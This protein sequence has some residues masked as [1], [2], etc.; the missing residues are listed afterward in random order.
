MTPNPFEFPVHH[1]PENVCYGHQ[2]LYPRWNFAQLFLVLVLRVLAA[3][4]RF[5][6]YMCFIFTGK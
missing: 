6:L 5:S 2:N 4:I 3:L 1:P